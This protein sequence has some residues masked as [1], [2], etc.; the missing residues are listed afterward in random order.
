MKI[1]ISFGDRF[2]ILDLFDNDIF[3]MGLLKY[4]PKDNINIEI[5]N[6]FLNRKKGDKVHYRD[7]DYEIKSV[8]K[9]SQ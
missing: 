6:A 4:N 3:E 1:T 7:R 5:N 8:I 9:K 2:E